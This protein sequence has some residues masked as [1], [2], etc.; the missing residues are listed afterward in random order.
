M[1]IKILKYSLFSELSEESPRDSSWR[2]NLL[3]TQKRVR[4]SHGKE[5]SMFVIEDCTYQKPR[6]ATTEKVFYCFLGLFCLNML[7]KYGKIWKGANM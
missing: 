4:I 1:K 3:G 7:R 6:F 2:K 5:S